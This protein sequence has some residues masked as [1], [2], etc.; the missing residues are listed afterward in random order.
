MQ[1]RLDGGSTIEL[2]T[3][4]VEV[5]ITLRAAAVR[6]VGHAGDHHVKEVHVHSLKLIIPALLCY[7]VTQNCFPKP[8]VVRFI[9]VVK[10][11][12]LKEGVRNMQRL[13]SRRRRFQVGNCEHF[14]RN[15]VVAVDVR[16]LTGISVF[17]GNHAVAQ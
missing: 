1:V 7:Q 10:R 17:Y 8:N 3:F 4:L 2:E 13:H 15:E 14:V 11:A 9:E 16:N 12:S 6:Q 5:E